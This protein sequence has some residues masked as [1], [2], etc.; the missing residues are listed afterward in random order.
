[1][2]TGFCVNKCWM[3]VKCNWIKCHVTIA[4]LYDKCAF[5]FTRICQVTFQNG[6][7]FTFPPAMYK[8]IQ[9]F[10]ILTI[11]LYFHII[12][13]SHSDRYLVTACCGFSLPFPKWLMILNIFFTCFFFFFV[14]C[15]SSL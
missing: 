3:L 4:G 14:I 5:S 2:C 10:C 9:F 13:F 1:M 11:T 15:I 8:W 7:H 6:C 12:N